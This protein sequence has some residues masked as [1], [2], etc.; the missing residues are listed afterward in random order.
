MRKSVRRARALHDAAGWFEPLENRVHLSAFSY[1]P[2]PM[3]VETPGPMWV[4]RPGGEDTSARAIGSSIAAAGD[5]DADGYADVIMGAGGGGPSGEDTRAMAAVYSGRTGEPIFTFSDG[6]TEF[7]ASVAG[8]G[9][10]NGDGRPD[11][12]IG[13]PRWNDDSG[14]P[15]S[16][17]RAYLYS[18]LDGSLLRTFEGTAAT[19]RFG[20]AVAGAG[21]VN[22]DGTPDLIIGAPGADRNGTDRGRAEVYSGADGTLLYR[23]LGFA[24]TDDARVG[25]AVSS[26]GDVNNDGYADLVVGAPGSTK[27]RV[28]APGTVFVYS[29]RTGAT[30]WTFSRGQARDE[31][32]FS[33]ASA[34]DVNNDGRGDIIIGAPSA[35]GV[36]TGTVPSGGRAVVY[37]GGDGH[38]LFEYFGDRPHANM[39]ASVAG[40]GDVNGDGHDDFI[41]GAPAAN[42]EARVDVRSG[43]DG[44][45]LTSFIAGDLALVGGDRIGRAAAAVGDVDRDGFIDFA[46]AA[47]QDA[48]P[49]KNDRARAYVFS[50]ARAAGL[51]PEGLND[52]RDIWGS[53]GFRHFVIL[54]GDLFAL[55]AR[56]GFLAG[57]RVLDVNNGHTI[58][59]ADKDGAPFLWTSAGRAELAGLIQSFVGPA[60]DFTGLRAVDI[61]DSGLILV[62]RMRGDAPTTWL[63][64]RGTLTYLFDGIPIAMNESRTVLANVA[65]RTDQS[66]L[67]T[68]SGEP[69]VINGIMGVDLN[70]GG[71]F[72]G[73]VPGAS[74][75][76]AVWSAGTITPLG[77]ISGGTDYK[78]A[79]LN[80]RGQVVGSYSVAGGTSGF[81][82]DPAEGI[83]DIKP[84][85]IAGAPDALASSDDLALPD[86]NS[87]GV[88]AGRINDARQG[89]LA[90][91]SNTSGPFDSRFNTRVNTV[92]TQ[93]GGVTVT[94]INSA[95]EVIIF[96]L[97][98]ST[99]AWTAQDLSQD[100][101]VA[102]VTDAVSWTDPATGRP[103]VA[104]ATSG[105]LILLTVDATG[106]WTAQNLTT[107]IPA[108]T[109]IESGLTS[110]IS[111]DGDVYI[112]GANVENDI[113]I[114][115]NSAGNWTYANLYENFLR[116]AGLPTPRFNSRLNAYVTSWN[117]L[118]ISGLDENGH[119][120]SV[121]TA[122]GLNGWSASDLSAI[123][124]AP[125]LAGGLTTYVTNW[126][127]INIL[128]I[129]ENGDTTVTWW[130]PEFGGN[131]R[132]NNFTAE[133]GGAR[134]VP[135]S[136]TSYVTPWNGLNVA[137][138]DRDGKIVSYWWVPGFDRWNVDEIPSG[139]DRA[140]RPVGRLESR[141]AEDGS[142]HLTGVGHD[143]HILHAFWSPD[144]PWQIDDLTAKTG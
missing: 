128:G 57:D 131:W 138:L 95:G 107:S 94:T 17:G 58:L 25:Y 46:F 88:I 65:G 124:G 26:A 29:G 62:E 102:N 78:P 117:G 70:E 112:A 136:V 118:N 98:G 141:A 52:A 55:P 3:L 54:R 34:G 7:G 89:F 8:V 132:Q 134:L 133:F 104:A 123:T 67:W 18:G 93:D 35:D 10:I 2:L 99:G 37:S 64:D 73:T 50:G 61:T 85:I 42:P 1:E 122:P 13:S 120:W 59:G 82:Y 32:G 113:V 115:R 5:V 105:G 139:E 119:V 36:G 135:G 87:R 4:L 126:G 81:F 77:V 106:M 16:A 11:L 71:A 23:F 68:G 111:I 14:G 21:D 30:L 22:K 143:G 79:G 74:T 24:I 38:M 43:A 19:D 72:V 51:L 96:R 103:A 97:D 48:N 121:W 101:A 12:L 130:V 129:D 137:G 142:I 75:L 31:F 90:S 83:A 108:A 33:V 60:D 63:Y 86:I 92:R 144:A 47:T 116:P 140:A 80:D 66:L 40:A 20:A 76:A 49:E 125:R 53:A 15:L 69:Q 45:I 84:L 39:G 91:Q 41:I 109:A 9:D 44:A 110:F 114:Y 28:D 6:F 127:G 56:D 100:T 27:G